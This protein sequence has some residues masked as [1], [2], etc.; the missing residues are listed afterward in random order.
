MQYPVLPWILA[1]YTSTTLDLFKPIGALNEERLAFF[2]DHYAEMSGR[3]FL[4]G[5]HYSAPGYVLYY[6]VRTV[7]QCVPVYP[8]SQLVLETAMDPIVGHIVTA[9]DVVA[10]TQCMVTVP[11][12]LDTLEHTDGLSVIKVIMES[13][14][15]RSVCFLIVL[16]KMIDV[17]QWRASIGLWNYCQAA[18]RESIVFKKYCRPASSGPASECCQDQLIKATTEDRD[19]ELNPGPTVEE[20][21][22]KLQQILRSHYDTLERATRGSLSNILS[23]LYTNNVITES[24]KDSESHNYSKMM[25]EFNTKLSLSKDVSE[26]KR[27][28][29]VFL[30]CISQGGPTDDA[31]RTLDSEWGQVF[32]I[33]SLIPIES[34]MMASTPSPSSPASTRSFFKDIS[35]SDGLST[36][37]LPASQLSSLSTIA[38]GASHD[39]TSPFKRK[40]SEMKVYKSLDDLHLKFVN[41]ANVFKLSLQEKIKQNSQLATDV[42]KWLIEYMEWDDGSVESNIDD[43]LKKIRPYYDFIDCKLLLDMSR[44]F[45]PNV[46]FTDDDEVTSKLIDELQSHICMSKKLRTSNTVSEL[47][48]LL[49]DHYK[50][51]E[52]DRNTD[53]LPCINIHLQTCWDDISIKGLRKLIKKLLPH[54]NR[55]SIIKH[56][57]II[58][59]SVVI[60]LHILDF[61]ADSLI[62]YTGGKLQFMRLIGI[63][64]LYIN[65]HRVLQEDENMNFTFE[66]ALLEAVTAGNNEAVKFLLQLKT[67][68]I[69]YTN[70]E[71]K[72]ALMLACERGHEDIV[73]SL[74]SAGAN[75]N[76]QDNK[77]WT[78]LMIA[79]KHNHISIIYM[80]LQAN[81]NPHMMKSNGSNAIMIASYYGNYE[82]AELLINKGVDYRY[83]RKD[84]WN[85]FMMTCQNG[86]TQIVKLLLKEQVD[87]N[88]QR[89][90]GGNA[91]MS[92]C[93]NGH[94]QIVELLL[95]EQVDPNVQKKDGWNAFMLACENG[96]TE[97]V[98]LLLKAQVDPN[99]QNRKGHTALMIASYKGHYELVKLL[100]ECE[101]DPTIKSKKGYTALKFAK[102][103]EI[104]IL[105]NSY[106]REHNLEEQDDAG[107][108]YSHTTGYHT[109]ASDIS[110]LRS[111]SSNSSLGSLSDISSDECNA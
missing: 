85:T 46:T 34:S 41:I 18:S 102:T 111:F 103:M 37:L 58:S 99:V 89:G 30:E 54:E 42:S 50:P 44:K 11:V 53:N 93:E 100:L 70:E 59:G 77:G 16:Y 71:G 48:K 86:H 27:H 83:Q 62:K 25:Q 45:L 107:S 35:V 7:Q 96:H 78:A 94:T 55:Q 39:I 38:G 40:T 98:K 76:I 23:K 56:I 92:A 61:T 109:V 108:V 79:S 60:K 51:F 3:K 1:D 47:K 91:F 43:I 87:P 15:L 73:H 28:C 104:S 24:V 14:V 13:T 10:V 2:K 65:D 17:S 31:A 105:L 66:L 19:V 63:F 64:S 95:K 81:A 21:C 97:V 72:T 29:Q 6:L 67:V 74:L 20:A 12:I 4:Y 80:L 49:Q 5:T 33:E 26:L 101:A 84:G 57:K 32:N 68:N 8:V 36:A 82:V 110:S 90:S 22:I 106:L 69:D 9:M 88:V 52:I 75:V